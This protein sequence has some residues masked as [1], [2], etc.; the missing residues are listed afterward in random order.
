MS[1]INNLIIKFVRS[2][3]FG[4]MV[5]QHFFR[6]WKGGRTETPKARKPRLFWGAVPILNNMYW[7]RA[8]KEAGYESTTVMR[9]FY[10]SMSKRSDFD[11]YFD[12]IIK[13]HYKSVP[14]VIKIYYMDYF[15]MDYILNH[16]DILHTSCDPITAVISKEE[17][18]ALAKRFGIK[19]IVIPYGG[20]AYR[21]SY[22]INVSRKHA[23]QISYPEAARMEKEIGAN[24]EACIRNAD[25][26]IS[27]FLFDG[28]GR[29][30]LL[31]CSPLTINT[32]TIK[33]KEFYSDHDG[34]N[35]E[36]VIAHA[37]NH[38]GAK[39]TDFVIH[40]VEELQKEGFKIRLKLIEKTSNDEL[41]R[42]LRDEVDLVVNELIG[43]FYGLFCVEAMATGLPILTNISIE[44]YTR[45]FRRFSYMNECPLVSATVE[46]VKDVLRPLI[47]NPQL[48]KEIGLAGR[49]FVEKYH[50]EKAA[51]FL[52]GNVYDKIWY[53]K[54]VD[55]MNLYHPLKK[56]SYNNQSPK[57]VHPLI[58][59]EI[60]EKYYKSQAV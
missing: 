23:I 47:T 17:E 13:D 36:V 25:I 26:F 59:N 48:R 21:Y 8:M 35:K 60:P 45:V 19:T 52:F 10:P 16:F 39:G 34:S 43:S 57:I 30:D 49:A 38:R 46:N 33:K 14:N 37:P 18:L 55:L 54:E 3:A 27:G 44:E 12:D 31:T 53:G 56:G 9:E 29:W 11:L 20:D 32:N 42:I 58:E 4:K 50:S 2:K 51:Q 7:S 40:A 24:V 28:V 41:L 15:V 5:R 22:L 1:A 6:K